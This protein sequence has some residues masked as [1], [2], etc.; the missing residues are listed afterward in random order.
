[1]DILNQI[2]APV[3]VFGDLH[4]Q[5]NDLNRFFD[6]FMGPEDDPNGD[7]ESTNYLFLGDYVDRGTKNLETILLLF[8]LKIKY[9][10]SV[11]LLRGPHE[12]KTINRSMG[13]GDECQAKLKEN[14]DDPGS[15][16]QRCNKIF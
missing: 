3:K 11:Y 5:I 2:R 9:P 6:E 10:E 7:I 1:M 8:S 14:I 15:F 16:F 12:D 4:G 13:F